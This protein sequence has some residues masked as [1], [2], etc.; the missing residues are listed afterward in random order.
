MKRDWIGELKQFK[1]FKDISKESGI[2]L[3]RLREYYHGRRKFD[4]TVKDYE[5][6][7]NLNRKTAYQ[8]FREYGAT[9]EMAEKYRRT[10]FDP[11]RKSIRTNHVRDVRE[12]NMSKGEVKYQLRLVANYINEEEGKLSYGIET[13]SW[14]YPKQDYKKQIAECINQAKFILGGYKWDLLEVLEEGWITYRG[15]KPVP[16]YG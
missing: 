5:K 1:T 14:A 2:P 9:P 13:F 11:N 10:F 8:Q 6:I 16:T 12:D 15:G 3:K 7:R 4:S